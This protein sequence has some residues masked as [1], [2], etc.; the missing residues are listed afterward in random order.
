MKT[1][2]AK[3]DAAPP[4]LDGAKVA[5]ASTQTLMTSTADVRLTTGTPSKM[6]R[7]SKV[8]EFSGLKRTQ[9]FEHVKAG[10]FPQP[11]R[12]TESGRAI[13]WDLAELLDWRERRLA[14]RAKPQ[15]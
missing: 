14:S 10:D 7:L 11:V 3:T 8:E 6:L 1:Q 5:A 2:P 12:L 4:L 15:Q 9:I 13:A